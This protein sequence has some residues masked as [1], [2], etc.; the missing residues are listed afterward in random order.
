M[1][2]R[3]ALY[4]FLVLQFP[5]WT[6][7]WNSVELN[8]TRVVMSAGM[9]KVEDGNIQVSVRVLVPA[10]NAS[11]GNQPSFPARVLSAEGATT[12]EAIRN[13]IMHAGYKLNFSHLRYLVLSKT[14]VGNDLASS[15]DLFFRDQEIRS[16]TY[17][18]ITERSPIEILG[19]PAVSNPI[20]SREIEENFKWGKSVG[21]Y[22]KVELFD[23]MEMLSSQDGVGFLPN[24]G[25]HTGKLPYL[26]VSGM[27]A[28]RKGNV[29]VDFDAE[30]T[31]GFLFTTGEEKNSLINVTVAKNQHVVAEIMNM[32]VKK[33]VKRQGEK[34]VLGFTVTC[35]GN[36]GSVK[37]AHTQTPQDYQTIE[38]QVSQR[39]QEEILNSFR[40]TQ[41][42]K[43]DLYRFSEAVHR[44]DAQYWKQH[45]N[46]WK[47]IY[48]QADVKVNV[49]TKLRLQGFNQNT[50]QPSQQGD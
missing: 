48:A 47:E 25:L 46:D 50:V 38:K 44:K 30:E 4:L 37:G 12:F 32:K 40:K 34:W 21:T 19:A 31:R 36:I 41:K 5:L 39:I 8:H 42:Y 16:R 45:R 27:T 1:K 49:S 28:F 2:R 14:L 22:P 20:Q 7:C 29:L 9:D 13:L 15:L 17:V 3:R 24:A 35:K 26:V 33:E 43:L 6:G 11:E 18:L 23:I 10:S